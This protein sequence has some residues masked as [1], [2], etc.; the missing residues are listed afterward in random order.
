MGSITECSPISTPLDWY[1]AVYSG[2][3][4]G[5]SQFVIKRPV[6]ADF[7]GYVGRNIYGMARKMT[8]LQGF[9]RP[10]LNQFFLSLKSAHSLDNGKVY[11]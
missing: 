2:L 8:R 1:T 9:G 3:L 11:F 6:P 5:Y 10:L 4:D 7:S